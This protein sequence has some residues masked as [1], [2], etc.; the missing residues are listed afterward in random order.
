MRMFSMPYNGTD[1]NEYLARLEPY[2]EHI[3][4]IFMGLPGIKSHAS[5]IVFDNSYDKHCA[6][7]LAAAKDAGYERSVTLNTSYHALSNDE[8][9]ELIDKIKDKLNY[10][11]PDTIICSSYRMAQEIRK[12]FPN[13]KINTSCNSFHDSIPQMRTWQE[14]VGIDLF[15]PPRS[16]ARD[17]PTLKKLKEHGFRLKVLVNE[18][19]FYGCPETLDHVIRP[20]YDR[21]GPCYRGKAENY[22]KG[23][24]VLPRWLDILDQ[25]VDVWKITG[26]Y[27]TSDYLFNILDHYV[28]GD[29]CWMEEI[30]GD[31]LKS[32]QFMERI[33]TE[34]IPDKLLYCRCEN[35]G[36][37]HTCQQLA[38]NY[39]DMRQSK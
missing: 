12:D 36:S 39:F 35:C 24:W 21:V 32:S 27:S 37:C 10:Y 26:R 15:N 18:Q 1:T 20:I 38:M 25:Y 2:R 9:Y 28:K 6:D 4:D 34:A 19:C 23:T 3:H 22:F 8:Y 11:Q 7:M 14:G 5:K 17:I 30:C 29:D 31:Y 33:R 13:I 16:A